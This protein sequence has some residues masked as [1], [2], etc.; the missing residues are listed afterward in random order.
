[1]TACKCIS[2]F[3]WSRHPSASPN[4]LNLSLQVHLSLHSISRSA[5]ASLSS[6]DLSLQVHFHTHP[7]T[8]SKY[9]IKERR[10]L[11]EDTGV[12]EVARVMGSIYS[13]DPGVDTHHL[14]SISSYHT[15]NIHTL[16]FPTFA[17][18][19]C[20]KFRRFVQLRGSSTP[21]SIISSHLIVTLLQPEPL[22]IM[23]SMWMLREVRWSV[24]RW[25]SAF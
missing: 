6:L 15:M 16:S 8:A 19:Q 12:M 17:L 5:S 21:G 13:A 20:P 7:I 18:T 4:E 24:D 1:M 25:L 10:R 9:I 2:E 11:Y 14:I 3:T 23:N 22:W